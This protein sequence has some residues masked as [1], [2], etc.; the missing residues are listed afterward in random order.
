MSRQRRLPHL[1]SSAAFAIVA[2]G[3]IQVDAAITS[4]ETTLLTNA[5]FEEAAADG[6]AAQWC[7]DYQRGYSRVLL[8]PAKYNYVMRASIPKTVPAAGRYAGTYRIVNLYQRQAA[9]VF[10]GAMIKGS[11]I[12]LDT[13]ALLIEQFNRV[14]SKVL[15]AVRHAPL[16]RRL[17]SI[18]GVGALAALNG[19]GAT[20]NV[21]FE[22]DCA[23]HPKF[24]E[25][26]G[27]PIDSTL[28]CAT[29]PSAGTFDWRWVGLDSH[30]CGIGYADS[31]TGNWI[32][33]PI[34]SAAIFPTVGG[35]TGTAYFDLIQLMQFPPGPG[36]VTFMF[37]DGFKSTRSTAKPILDKYGFVGSSAVVSD[38]VGTTGHMIPQ[39]LRD[40]Q[41][42]GGDIASHSVTHPSMP[43]LSIAAAETE[44]QNSK[45]TLTRLGLTIDSFVWPEGDYNKNLI[46]LAQ[47]GLTTA[48]LY[49]SARNTEFDDNAYGTFPYALKT[50]EMLQTTP[51]Q[52]VQAWINDLKVGGRWGIFILHDVVDNPG[53]YAISP[54]MLDQLAQ[55]VA[56]SGVA[57]INYRQ[58]YQ[59]FANIP[60]P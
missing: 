9:N 32:N 27:N 44:L 8:T 53:Q 59:T 25:Y 51:L 29:L 35:A 33:V 10:V 1:L 52:D 31:A 3:A 14:H 7:D 2:A 34:K 24:C 12:V 39:D 36:A 57:V 28:W 19:L 55:L 46:G 26:H 42:A 54:T 17:M 58:G 11:D 6:K 56:S 21:G 4:C 30:T 48:P 60:A 50:L 16:W 43:G 20:L 15:D 22:V 40:L 38:L 18:P 23:A 45:S 41:A 13:R 37:D 47:A 49:K 5:D